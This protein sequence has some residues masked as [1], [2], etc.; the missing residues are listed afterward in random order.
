L[1]TTHDDKLVAIDGKS[2][3]LVDAHKEFGT[4]VS[5]EEEEKIREEN[6]WCEEA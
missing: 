4:G 2:V 3:Y 6:R 1:R 5:P